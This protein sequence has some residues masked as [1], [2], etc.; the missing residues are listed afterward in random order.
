MTKKWIGIYIFRLLHK[1]LPWREH[2]GLNTKEGFMQN[3]KLMWNFP[4]DNTST[5]QPI[6]LLCKYMC[7]IRGS[8]IS[9]SFHLFHEWWYSYPMT[10]KCLL[11][12]TYINPSMKGTLAV[13]CTRE[14]FM[15][16]QQMIWNLP[17]HIVRYVVMI[18]IA[19]FKAMSGYLLFPTFA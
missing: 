4:F 19:T 8:S 6:S 12:L 5:D 11:Y 2:W 18:F 13:N 10:K 17:L 9:S 16:K 14:G 7:W 15:Q 3:L 1:S